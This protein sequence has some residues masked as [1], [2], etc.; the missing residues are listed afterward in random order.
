MNVRITIDIGE[1]LIAT[2]YAEELAH[3]VAAGATA[4]H[5]QLWPH[6]QEARAVRGCR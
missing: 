6:V 5:E 1:D 4:A 3:A 2:R